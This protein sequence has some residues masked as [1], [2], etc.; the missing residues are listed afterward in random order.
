M[1]GLRAVGQQANPDA[2]MDVVNELSRKSGVEIKQDGLGSQGGRDIDTGSKTGT[3]IRKVQKTADGMGLKVEDR[4]T[5]TTV[6]GKTTDGKAIKETT[7][8]SAGGQKSA[9]GSSA[10]Q[11]EKNWNDPEHYT[12]QYDS[13]NGGIRVD[14]KGNPV[15]SVSDH[16]GKTH[17][18]GKG[19]PLSSEHPLNKNPGQMTPQDVQ[20]M[21]KITGKAMESGG[22]N[23][24][25]LQAKLNGIKNGQPVEDVASLQQQCKDAAA[26]AVRNENAKIQK[27][28]AQ[29][30]AEVD[31]AKSKYDQA[32]AGGD[33]AAIQ[34]AKQEFETAKTKAIEFNEHT[35]AAQRKAIQNGATDAYAEANGYKPNGKG[36]YVDPATGETVSASKMAENA[37]SKNKINLTTKQTTSAAKPPPA[38][39]PVTKA[40]GGALMIIGAIKSKIDGHKQAQEEAQPGDSPVKTYVKGEIYSVLNFTGVSH[41]MQTGNAAA[42]AT[43]KEWKQAVQDGSISGSG[44]SGTLWKLYY[45]GK[46]GV[47]GG[48]NQTKAIF[49]DPF[50]DAKT[51]IDEGLGLVDDNQ[52]AKENEKAAKEVEKEKEHKK[53]EKQGATKKNDTQKSGGGSIAVPSG[54]PTPTQISKPSVPAKPVQSP[55][56]S[57]GISGQGTSGTGGQP[58]KP[59]VSTAKPPVSTAPVKPPSTPPVVKTPV[60]QSPPK[61]Q[62]PP[63]GEPT[64]LPPQPGDGWI[65]VPGTGSVPMEAGVD[66]TAPNTNAIVYARDGQMQKCW[67]CNK[68]V[69]VLCDV[70][71]GKGGSINGI[72]QECAKKQGAGQPAAGFDSEDMRFPCAMCGLTCLKPELVP[73]S[74]NPQV[75]VCPRCTDIDYAILSRDDW[76]GASATYKCFH[77]GK[78][79]SD[80]RTE[81]GEPIPQGDGTSTIP[82]KNYCPNCGAMLGTGK[83]GTKKELFEAD[84]ANWAAIQGPKCAGCGAAMWS[85]FNDEVLAEAKTTG[86]VES[87]QMLYYCDQCKGTVAAPE[88]TEVTVGDLRGS[89]ATRQESPD[90]ELS[91]RPPPR[92]LAGLVDG[93]DEKISKR[94]DA[95]LSLMGDNTDVAQASNIGNQ[96]IQDAKR[97]RDSGGQEANQI[98][99]TSQ[100]KIRIE[101]VKDNNLLATA[102]LDGVGKGLSTAGGNFGR[103]LGA[104]AAN[105]IFKPKNSSPPSSP[106]GGTAPPSGASPPTT[107]GKG[108]S[109]PPSGSSGGGRGSGGGGGGSGGGSGGTGSGSG[110]GSSSETLADASCPVCGQMYNPAYG[111]LCP[112]ASGGTI[113]ADA[114]CPVCGQMYNPANGH[115]CPGA[116]PPPSQEP[117]CDLCG[118]TPASSVSTVDAGAKTLCNACKGSHRC[119]QCG[120]TTMEFHSTGYGYE[121]TNP[122][123]STSS[124]WG[125]IEGVCQNCIDQWRRD[126]GL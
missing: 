62:T 14:A 31:A 81:Y 35:Q 1:T 2:G 10:W 93:R 90:E 125:N 117:G 41:G 75:L 33:K 22:V 96:T 114:L 63:S 103:G 109:Q 43:V 118:R 25:E 29:L 89:E 100:Q 32:K 94:T 83:G 76:D 11:S 86:K 124:R 38:M 64:T 91:D 88:A 106:A 30:K 119:P 69:F 107:G 80:L 82:A 42:D 123:G 84:L 45:A 50:L 54:S 4:I 48:I 73:A 55:V 102:I 116:A 113:L 126:Q 39:R 12:G 47:K 104:G 77:C 65:N 7:I 122:D 53:K 92:A 108:D 110:G 27:E 115:Q 85:K 101:E 23:N 6:S 21:A 61:V 99:K 112:G 72:C 56:A 57:T 70:P 36:G 44:V 87:P 120:N 5:S 26:Q 13:K 59:P 17:T 16:L 24:P 78:T 111:H 3:E 98:A 52:K 79:M 71:D 20:D 95:G 19:N 105:E 40:T 66:W 37:A 60:V 18:D 58:A 46:A 97:T 68:E 28:G 49:V 67:M 9:V 121:V 8:H 74:F 34:S 51:A 15:P